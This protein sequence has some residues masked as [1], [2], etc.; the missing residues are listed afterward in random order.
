MFVFVKLRLPRL[1]QA[2]QVVHPLCGLYDKA[3]ALV[4]AMFHN[5]VGAVAHSRLLELALVSEKHY[6]ETNHVS[7]PWQRIG[8]KM[9]GCNLEKVGFFRKEQIE[10]KEQFIWR[11][12]AGC[13][14]IACQEKGQLLFFLK[15]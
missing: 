3:F 10:K 4:I 5:S 6:A 15:K 2:A 7:K 13:L 14:K 9:L 12:N 11:C 1:E 8:F